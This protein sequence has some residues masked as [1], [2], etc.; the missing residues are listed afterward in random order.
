MTESSRH[1]WKKLRSQAGR[2]LGDQ[3]WHDIAG[4]LPLEGPR[5]DVYQKDDRVFVVI[6][7]PGCKANRSLKLSVHDRVLHVRGDIVCP[8]PIEEEDRFVAERFFGPF[9]RKIELPAGVS[10]EGMKAR[11]ND[12]LLTVEFVRRPVAEAIDIVVETADASDEAP[13]ESRET[14]RGN[15]GS[16]HFGA[17]SDA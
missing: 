10:A 6:E 4:L 5:T 11:Y 3:F 2:A 1:F 12:G 14:P 15:T 8:Y 7:L 16:D 17:R 9:H 13:A